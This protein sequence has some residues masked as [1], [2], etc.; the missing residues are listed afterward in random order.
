[1][2]SAVGPLSLLEFF[3]LSVSTEVQNEALAG[4]HNCML[5]NQE[6]EMRLKQKILLF[7]PMRDGTV[8]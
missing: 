6:S 3:S 4:E 2:M 8:N 7:R 5:P 1:M